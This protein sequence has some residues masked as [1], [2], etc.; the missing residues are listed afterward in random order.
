[1]IMKG[2]M[3]DRREA[4]D[5]RAR[6]ARRRAFNVRSVFRVSSRRGFSLV[7]ILIVLAVVGIIALV[8]TG[9]FS[10]AA[11][12]EALD[13]ETAIA[14]SLIEQARNQT[15]SAKNAAAYGVHFETTKAVL[16]AGSSYSASNSSNV[17]EPINPLVQISAVS[18]KGGGNEV[19]F[20]RLTGETDQNGTITFSLVSSPAQAETITIFG[21][22]L[23]QS[24]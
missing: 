13:K 4:E 18:L 24:I 19:I 1:M 10:K 22:G 5:G 9:A 21:T 14:L 8:V 16:F 17:V 11:G 20:K 3:R 23:A 7:E 12:R 6:S 2:E 15:L